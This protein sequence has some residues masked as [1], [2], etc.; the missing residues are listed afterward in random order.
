MAA[1]ARKSPIIRPP[2]RRLCALAPA[3]SCCCSQARCPRTVTT[4][5]RR[6]T[7]SPSLVTHSRATSSSS[8][9]ARRTPG[10]TSR[11][12]TLRAASQRYGAE[13]SNPSAAR[14]RRRVARHVPARR[15]GV[16]HRLA[17]TRCRRP[18][19]SP[20]EGRRAS[21]A[22]SGAGT[23]AG[24]DGAGAAPLLEAVLLLERRPGGLHLQE[25]A[26][27]IRSAETGSSPVRA[28]SSSS[29]AR[30]SRVRARSSSSRAPQCSSR[31][32]LFHSSSAAASS[33]VP[34][35]LPTNTRSPVISSSYDDSKSAM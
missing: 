18:P 35:T 14:A 15:S 7:S 10:S 32:R 26:R 20:E 9:I 5:S 2:C 22:A 25:L 27:A 1:A 11:C 28:P 4:R 29:G 30:R 13:W 24:A 3:C 12:A 31:C 19:D 8:S 23:A 17:G 6:C 34:P 33:G 16:D 21:A